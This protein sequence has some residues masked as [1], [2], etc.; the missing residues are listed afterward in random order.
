MYFLI[1]GLLSNVVVL[2]QCSTFRVKPYVSIIQVYCKVVAC[3]IT[4]SIVSIV[5]VYYKCTV[6]VVLVWPPRHEGQKA[7]PDF[8]L[9]FCRIKHHP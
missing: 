7:V 1:A 2:Q 8:I 9:T 6:T 5:L 4:V 3:N